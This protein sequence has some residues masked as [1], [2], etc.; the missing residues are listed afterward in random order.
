MLISLLFV[1][2]V[3][4]TII[5]KKALVLN[6]I[7]LLLISWSFLFILY[8]FSGINYYLSLE[9]LTVVYLL[10]TIVI[11]IVFRILGE[12]IPLR[13]KREDNLQ[14]DRINMKPYFLLALLGLILR[15]YDIVSLNGF[16]DISRINRTS[17]IIGV[18][19]SLLTPLGLVIGIY[20][21]NKCLKHK[22]NISLLA[23]SSFLVYITPV[24]L[25]SGRMN[26][27]IF[28][29]TVF[30]IL[31]IYFDDAKGTKPK[32]RSRSK[33]KMFKY[34][35]VLFLLFFSLIVY[36][37]KIVETR[38]SSSAQM[39]AVLEGNG[40][41]ISSEALETYK[42]TGYFS[43]V[44]VN[45]AFYYSH[46]LS[47]L[48]GLYQSYDGPY[49]FGLTQ[50]PYVA[51]RLPNELQSIVY[52]SV[53]ALESLNSLYG[54]T[55]FVSSGWKTIVG[56]MI[57]DFGKLG[58][59]IMFS[60]LGFFLGR[61]RKEFNENK[62]N[63]RLTVQVLICVSVLFSIHYSPFFEASLAYCFIWLF[64]IKKNHMFLKGRL[65]TKKC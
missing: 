15:T 64:I 56:H 54:V 52:D 42:S 23:I 26:I 13:T 3:A 11:F 58:S 34:L 10:L 14:L 57:I 28:L 18:I 37:D 50:L 4:S 24:I 32:R 30:I 36:S 27:L 17:S 22:K 62:N 5:F 9:Y 45:V 8:Y 29:F 31:F 53:I 19:G 33:K 43:D 38:F 6:D 44:L 39:V 59:V 49:T 47:M 7:F 1:F 12:R 21:T 60:F 20:E 61:K 25:L 51:R 55:G 63:Y 65:E 40:S 35:F 41:Y 2:L 48:Q 16:L 46:Q